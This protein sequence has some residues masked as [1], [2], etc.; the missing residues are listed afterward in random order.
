ML[1]KDEV[2]GKTSEEA[3]IADSDY[4]YKKIHD[5]IMTKVRCSTQEGKEKMVYMSSGMYIQRARKFL[6]GEEGLAS[7]A[8]FF[9]FL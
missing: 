5:L 3:V 7:E 8:V 4:F 9:N 2:T 6:F 1:K